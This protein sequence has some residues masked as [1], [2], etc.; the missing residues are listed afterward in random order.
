MRQ[1][2]LTVNMCINLVPPFVNKVIPS[3]IT[4]GW[5]GTRVQGNLEAESFQPFHE[6]VLQTDGMQFIEVVGTEIA[7]LDW[8]MEDAKSNAQESMRDGDGGSLDTSTCS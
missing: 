1:S 3:K 2:K 8:I 7:I 4:L 6:P 5:K